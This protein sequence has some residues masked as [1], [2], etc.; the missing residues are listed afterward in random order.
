MLPERKVRYYNESLDEYFLNMKQLRFR[1]NV[2]DSALIQYIINGIEDPVLKKYFRYGSQNIN[3]F[4]QKLIIYEK[5]RFGYDNVK[6]HAPGVNTRRKIT[7][8]VKF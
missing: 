1:G 7:P 3:K 5:W 6:S 8:E 2:G 4:M